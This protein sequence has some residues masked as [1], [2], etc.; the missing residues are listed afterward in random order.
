VRPELLAEQMHPGVGS[1]GF[2]E[3]S[4]AMGGYDTR[5]RL[6]EIEIPTLVVWGLSDRIVPVEAAIGYHRLIAGSRLE[7]FERTGHVP[8]MERPARFNA[9]LDEFLAE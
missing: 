8:Q 1:P 5:H 6:P 2:R 3:A 7:I 4:R 9:L